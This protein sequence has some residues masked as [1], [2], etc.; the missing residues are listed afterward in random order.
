[1]RVPDT[2]Q[3]IPER[4]RMLVARLDRLA[5]EQVARKAEIETRWLED[6]R[7]YHARYSSDAEQRMKDEGGSALYVGLTRA[8]TNAWESR[9]S[10]MMFPTDDKNWGVS[11]TPVP[12]LTEV[13]RA[14][15]DQAKQLTAA[16]NDALQQGQPTDQIVANAEAAAETAAAAKREMDEA[17]KRAAAMENEIEDQLVE[18]KYNQHYRRAILDTVKLGTGVMK[19]PMRSARRSRQWQRGPDG[20]FALI[21][22]EN[23]VPEFRRVDPWSYFPDMSART[24]DEAEFEFERYLYTAKDLRKLAKQPGFDADAIRRILRNKPKEA[25][26]SYMPTL[27]GITGKSDPV[28]DRYICWEYHGPL[29]PADME[30]FGDEFDPLEEQRVIIWFCDGELIKAGVHPLDSGDSLYSVVNFEPDDTCVFGFG[31]PYL[32][33]DSQA[34]VNAAWRMA[35]DNGALSMGPQVVVD[36]SQIE[37]SDGDWTIRPKKLW[38]KKSGSIPNARPFE[39]Y[40]IP[41]RQGELFNIISLAMQ[42]IDIETNMPVFAQGEPGSRSSTPAG[43]NTV[44]GLSILM[45]AANVVFRRVIKSFDDHMTMPN[46]R[47]MYDWNMQFSEKEDIKGDMQVQARGSSVLLIR[48]IQAQN[49]MSVVTNWSVHPVLGALLK[50]APAARKTLQAL[51]VSADEVLKTDE[52]LQDEASRQQEQPEQPSPDLIKSQTQLQLA[53]LDAATKREVAQFNRETELIKLAEQRNMQLE[54]LRAKLE[55][56]SMDHRSKE[57]IFAAE[58]A[59][60][61][62]RDVTAPNRPGSGGFLS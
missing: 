49:L 35:I 1:M 3:N 9:I 37:P 25:V 41:S 28:S 55:I 18:S 34:A 23:I 6:L 50:A 5:Q 24:P 48:E 26:P 21:E 42:F 56:K 36:R 51:M 7:N 19:G 22:I 58:A 8:K 59:V 13:A 45:N 4:L 31:V 11:P 27:R 15:A 39:V 54:D 61:Q 47:R 32:T 10:D 30:L 53:E 38:F 60:E 14:A 17:R 62:R 20:V 16:A 57:R 29:E 2:E 44:G 12:S 46:I 40:D 43:A 52:E 33:R